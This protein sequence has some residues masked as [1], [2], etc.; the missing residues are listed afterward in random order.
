MR[1]ALHGEVASSHMFHAVYPPEIE[2]DRECSRQRKLLCWLWMGHQ[3]HT[4]SNGTP[5]SYSLYY[6]CATKCKRP[7]VLPSALFLGFSATGRQRRW[8]EEHCTASWVDTGST[9]WYLLPQSPRLGIIFSSSDCYVYLEYIT[10]CC[11]T[12][13]KGEVGSVLHWQ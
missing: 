12:S 1:P 2:E 3:A 11:R 7:L 6:R 13:G 5:F 10:K 9:I 4:P 8:E